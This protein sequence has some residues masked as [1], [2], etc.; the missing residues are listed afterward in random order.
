MNDTAAGEAH[1]LRLQ[2][3]QCLGEVLA[4]AVT[5]IGILR[6]QRHHVDIHVAGVEHEH[7]EG[8][9]LTGRV[10]SEH[11]LVLLPGV[12]AHVDDRLSQQ[13]GILG[14][15]SLLLLDECH[16]HLLGATTDVTQESGEVV[17]LAS[18]HRDTVETVVLETEAFPALIVIVFLHTLGVE[19]HVVGIVGMDGV[20][21]THLQGAQRVSWTDHLPGR[22]RPPAVALNGRE[23][24][25]AVLYQFGIEAAI[26]RV[27]DVLEEDT[28][29]FVTNLFTALWG[30]HGLL[31]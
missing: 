8:G 17:L 19:A 1:E 6:H 27:V 7:L 28:D 21:L 10:G 13:F 23:L 22:A 18:L 12:I 15:P 3:G 24:E 16:A 2:V 9:L 31:R 20:V 29:Q 11:G 5:L 14:R 26:S 30:C 4:D 25:R